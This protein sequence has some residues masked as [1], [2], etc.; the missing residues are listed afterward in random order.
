MASTLSIARPARSSVE[1]ADG[2]YRLQ[3]LDRALSILELLGESE[4]PLSLAEI[5]RRMNLHKSTVHRALNVLER[6]MLLERTPENS[7]RL[8]LKLFDLGNRAVRQMDLRTRIRPFARRL[9]AQIGETV[10]LGVLQKTSVVYLDKTGPGNRVCIGSKTGSS[11]P[12]HC[13]SL[14]KAMLAWLPQ[15]A[16]NELIDQMTFVRFTSKT[17]C[18]REE[19][20]EALQRVRR[21]GYSVDDEEVET[22][23][24]CIGAPI[25]DDLGAP[26]AALS[27]SCI[28]SRIQSHQVPVLAGRLVR[29]CSDISESL[30]FHRKIRTHALGEME[31]TAS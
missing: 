12:A 21:R 27:V 20:L 10:H 11:N 3:S 6:G 28:S 1:P 4:V 14:G 13:T 5:C 24:R 25:F 17:I 22:G 8:G 29:C 15:D 30:R 26:I 9:S 7:F 18:S 19:L 16:I 2:P 23:V 31:Q